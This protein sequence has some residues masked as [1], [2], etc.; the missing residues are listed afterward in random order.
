MERTYLACYLKSIHSYDLFIK[1]IRPAPKS[2]SAF[3]FDQE[4]KQVQ[5]LTSCWMLEI[6]IDQRLALLVNS[7]SISCNTVVH[8]ETGVFVLYK[9]SLLLVGIWTSSSLLLFFSMNALRTPCLKKSRLSATIL[10]IKCSWDW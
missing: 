4:C 10:L 7:I 8:A 2:A 3:L 5:I 6:K 9:I 1:K